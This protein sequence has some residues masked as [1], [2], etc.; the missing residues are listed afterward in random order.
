VFCQPRL[1][2]GNV[3]ENV[4]RAYVI[5][6]ELLIHSSHSEQHASR[7]D[8]SGRTKL[9]SFEHL[10][11][12]IGQ[13]LDLGD[14]HFGFSSAGVEQLRIATGQ[15]RSGLCKMVSEILIGENSARA[16]V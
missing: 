13:T 4:D 5:R 12:H 15:E 11:R 14:R 7:Y 10:A 9:V 3:E 8:Y 6:V 1:G 16:G 2:G